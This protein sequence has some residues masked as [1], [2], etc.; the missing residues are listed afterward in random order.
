MP[1]WLYIKVKP[2]INFLK[3]IPTEFSDVYIG[4]AFLCHDY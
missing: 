1:V 4:Y 3:V 2:N